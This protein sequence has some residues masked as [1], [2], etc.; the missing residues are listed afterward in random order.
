MLAKFRLALII[1]V[2]LSI[3]AACAAPLHLPKIDRQP[4][5][6]G[7]YGSI[8]PNPSLPAKLD[9]TSETIFQNDYRSADLSQLD[10]S[11]S[12]EGLLIADF[13]SQTQWPSASRLPAGF[14]P[15]SIMELGKDPGLGVRAL[16]DSGITGKGIGI[17]I[18]D[19]TLVVDH[20]EYGSQL[21]LYE[22][23]NYGSNSEAEMHGPAV[24]SLAVGKDIGTAPEASLYLIAAWPAK[25]NSSSGEDYEL[26]YSYMAQAVRRIMEV[27]RSLP[28]ADKI[29][30]ISMSMGFQKD[31][32]GYD[33]L[34]KSFNEAKN[35]GIFIISMN[36]PDTYGWNMLGLGRNPAADPNDFNSF[37]PSPFR[38]AE[39]FSDPDSNKD[40][41]YVPMDA[42]TTASPTGKSDYV[43]YGLGGMSWTAPYLAG[44]YALACQVDPQITPAKF[45]STAL[46]TG[47]TIQIQHEGKAFSFGKIIDPPALIEALQDK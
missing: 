22:E 28:K 45:W 10:L 42:R 2:V 43:F 39:F 18:I 5:S 4:A 3:L 23:I 44:I 7:Y 37:G 30:V 17:A 32:K 19:A 26:D 33:E 27:N 47:R 8:N 29:R 21:R 16:H 1:I 9:P 38:A 34:M 31:Q 6:P 46:E 20:Q 35:A 15:R 24:A 12:L 11:Q 41:L 14:D 13:D 25:R 36:L 40:F